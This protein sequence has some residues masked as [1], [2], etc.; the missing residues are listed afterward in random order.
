MFYLELQRIKRGNSSPR[1]GTSLACRGLLFFTTT[2][3][4]DIVVGTEAR[5]GSIS[6]GET[7][8]GLGKDGASSH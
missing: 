1:S 7:L 4:D 3:C 8:S 2:G 6:H 5:I